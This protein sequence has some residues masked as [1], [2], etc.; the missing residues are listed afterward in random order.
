MHLVLKRW[1][2]LAFVS[3]FSVEDFETILDNES[4]E[5]TKRKTFTVTLVPKTKVVK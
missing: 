3:E 2:F 5:R 4:P 1:N